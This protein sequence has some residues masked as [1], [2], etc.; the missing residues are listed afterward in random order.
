MNR[1]R[2]Y[3]EGMHNRSTIEDKPCSYL[4]VTLSGKERSELD[5]RP[6][7]MAPH[8]GVGRQGGG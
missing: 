5:D 2:R 1:A 8:H 3:T 6:E 7:R 4:N